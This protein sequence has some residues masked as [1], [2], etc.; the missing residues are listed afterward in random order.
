MCLEA[1]ARDAKLAIHSRNLIGDAGVRGIVRLNR[2]RGT[3]VVV[4]IVVSAGA[5]APSVQAKGE[6]NARVC[7]RAVCRV[8]DH[9]PAFG[10][11]GAAPIP[12]DAPP[13][14]AAFYRITIS[15]RHAPRAP[16]QLVY[17]PEHDLVHG[18]GGWAKVSASFAARMRR[19]LRGV[20]PIPAPAHPRSRVL[21]STA[22]S[23]SGADG[24]TKP[25][26]TS[27]LGYIALAALGALTFGLRSSRRPKS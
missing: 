26:L 22:G 10:K 7:G 27:G 9:L 5:L 15:Y 12:V 20:A 17:V 16:Q 1:E 18:F 11:A 2:C 21:A 3:A 25:P 24:R 8:V 13:L 6:Y 23:L 4:G 19:S 14:P